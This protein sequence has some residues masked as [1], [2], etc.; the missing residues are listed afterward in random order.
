MH[1]SFH[2]PAG[3]VFFLFLLHRNNRAVVRINDDFGNLLRNPAWQRVEM[4]QI[5]LPCSFSNSLSLIVPLG[6]RVSAVDLASA[7]LI[8][9]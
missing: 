8:L 1:G 3:L 4:S 5:N 2:R 7:S 9:D 6:A